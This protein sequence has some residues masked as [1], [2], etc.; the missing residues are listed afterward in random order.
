MFRRLTERHPRLPDIVAITMYLLVAAVLAIPSPQDPNLL[1][2]WSCLLFAAAGAT[3]LAFRR[4]RPLWVFAASNLL[5]LASVYTGT[6]A[7]LAL[8]L[9]AVY[10]IGVL[11]SARV[12]WICYGIGAVIMTAAGTILTAR[13]RWGAPFSEATQPPSGSTFWVDWLNLT[14]ALMLV[15]V[16]ACLLGANA[17]V[18]RRHVAA[19]VDRARQLMRER[20]QQAEIAAAGERERIARE[21][22]DI[23][24]HSLS[25]V[26]TVSEGAYAAAPE[27]PDEAREAIKRVAETGRRALGEVRRLLNTV[28]EH[29]TA[30]AVEHAPQPDAGQLSTLADE[31]RLAGLPVRLD[32]A[33]SPSP[34]PA[35]GLTVYRIVQES[36]TN[37]LRHAT[38][39]TEVIA[40]VTWTDDYVEIYVADDA[41]H[42]ASAAS[43]GR[44][45]VGI[46]ERAALYNGRVTAG[47]QESGG[48]QVQV[49][50]RRA[51]K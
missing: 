27:R 5:F 48:W 1:P 14:I 47:P 37:A 7:E 25:I 30:T 19:L 45:I 23:I 20:D 4:S 44:G 6:G 35:L 18:R 34:D 33:G 17:G 26:I 39:A 42:S 9:I 10:T 3:V 40:S 41:P 13:A 8:P 46:R 31:F 38:G 22:H 21:M 12:A 15:Y 28:R 43:P 36:L 2:L 11:R 16:I 49:L 24:A 50:L 51:E 32:F 29:D